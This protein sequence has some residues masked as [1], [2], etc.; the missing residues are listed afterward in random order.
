[1]TEYVVVDAFPVEP[2]HAQKVLLVH[3][4]RPDY[5][6][7]IFNMVGG[8]LEPGE[9]PI[10]A[11][12]RELQEE[13]GLDELQNYDPMVFY[14]SEYCGMVLGTKSSIHCVKVPVSFRQK[15]TPRKEETEPVA[16]FD[17]CDA[18]NHPKLMPN[19]RVVLPLIRSG[20]RGWKLVVGHSDWHDENHRMEIIFSG[21]DLPITAIV[22]GLAYYEL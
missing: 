3:K 15:L 4:N 18:L 9:N 21:T 13:A 5:L 1:M 20:A 11:A 7:G 14:P 19:L 6:K 8:K 22:K 12:I 17:Y 2:N 10:Q 16:W